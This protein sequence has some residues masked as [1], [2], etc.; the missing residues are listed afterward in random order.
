MSVPGEDIVCRFVR[1]EDWSVR[2][3]RPKPG[4]FKQPNLSAWHRERLLSHGAS[5]EDLRIQHL[6]GCGQAHHIAADYVVLAEEAAQT[7]GTVFCVQVEWRTGDEHVGEPWRS[8]R[9]AH[10]QVEA[11]DG[12]A[13]FL[14]EFRRMLAQRARTIIP[15][16]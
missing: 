9:Y 7:E 8:W 3:K 1:K 16:D 6:A 5:L 12:P 10:V 15:P 11:V 13:N 14:V 2:D 4:A